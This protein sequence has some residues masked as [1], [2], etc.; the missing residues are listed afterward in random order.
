MSIALPYFISILLSFP[1]I[2]P[3]DGWVQWQFAFPNKATCEEF[4]SEQHETLFVNVTRAFIS[5]PHVINTME[6]MTVEE[7]IE[8]NKALGHHKTPQ[9]HRIPKP[10]SST[11]PR[12]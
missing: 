3:S 2:L 8:K 5:M 12:V 11:V 9:L 4:L 6:C 10:K 1:L 7:G